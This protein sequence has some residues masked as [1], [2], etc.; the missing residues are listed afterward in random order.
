M[1]EKKV[2]LTGDIKEMYHAVRISLLHQ[3]ISSYGGTWKQ[4]ANR[5]LIP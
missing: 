3:H 2:A 4:N 5:T 1:S